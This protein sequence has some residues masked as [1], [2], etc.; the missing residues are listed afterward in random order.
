MARVRV[1]Q[2]T[3]SK[4]RPRLRVGKAAKQ[5]MRVG[6]VEGGGGEGANSGGGRGA[7]LSITYSC[8]GSPT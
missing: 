5:T 2:H 4:K 6:N 8:S 7:E 1:R 3:A